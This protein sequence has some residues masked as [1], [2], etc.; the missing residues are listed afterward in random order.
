VS[1]DN[2]KI[3]VENVGK[4]TGQAPHGGHALF[5]PKQ[6]VSPSATL[7]G[8]VSLTQS[9][10]QFLPTQL[11]IGGDASGRMLRHATHMH[12]ARNPPERAA[13]DQ[14]AGAR[15]YLRQAEGPK[16]VV[17]ALRFSQCEQTLL[18]LGHVV[19]PLSDLIHDGL[20]TALCCKG[21]ERFGTAVVRVNGLLENAQFFVYQGLQCP[22]IFLL[23]WIVGC[24]AT[25]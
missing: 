7:L 8:S 1:N 17:S 22:Q 21:V 24:L 9:A 14:D 23:T 15:A 16:G 25:E 11:Q 2:G 4:P 3:V 20:A 19:D 6:Y 12:C 18:L 13:D 10:R 5:T